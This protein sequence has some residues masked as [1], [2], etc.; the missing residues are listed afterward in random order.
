MCKNARNEQVQE[1]ENL[2]LF[3]W[4]KAKAKAKKKNK[5]NIDFSWKTEKVKIK[6]GKNKNFP[7]IYDEMHERKEKRRKESECN[8]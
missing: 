4:K 5:L 6:I 3:N 2:F 1:P 7:R 8:E